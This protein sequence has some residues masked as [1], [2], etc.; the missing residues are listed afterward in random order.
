VILVPTTATA[1][2]AG[3]AG[4]ILTSGEYG[5]LQTRGPCS[6]LINGTPAV[7]SPVVYSGTTTGA[8]DVWTTAA[9]AVTTEPIG[10]MMQVGVST[11]FNFVFLTI[12]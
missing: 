12:D 1:K 11:K 9:A 3:V 5:W 10:H 7:T 8:V 4:C 2:V 6:V